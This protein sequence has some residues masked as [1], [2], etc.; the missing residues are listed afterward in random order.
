MA[1]LNNMHQFKARMDALSRSIGNMRPRRPKPRTDTFSAAMIEATNPD[2][3]K[4][5]SSHK[6]FKVADHI[7]ADVESLVE[8]HSKDS[9]LDPEL[10][11]QLIAVASGNNPMAVG[12]DGEIG[13][14]QV[15]PEVF[16][17]LGLSNPFDPDQ[18]IK[19][20]TTHLASLMQRNGGNLPLSLA[21]YNSSPATVRQFGGVPPFSGTQNFVNQILTGI[22]SDDRSKQGR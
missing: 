1:M 15:K 18:N 19:A 3:P 4:S 8:K 13:L 11:R 10:V 16:G 17:Q 6:D 21:S 22:G 9:G 2:G 12:P 7:K 5:V 20:G 14:M